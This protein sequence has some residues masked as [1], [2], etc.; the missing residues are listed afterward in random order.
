MNDT[1]RDERVA[2]ATLD[3]ADAAFDYRIREVE[4]RLDRRVAALESQ[5]D[6]LRW[7]NRLMGAGLA[8]SLVAIVA[9]LATVSGGQRT[10]A[11]RSLHAEE[12]VLRDGYGVMRGRL[13]TDSDG[14]ALLS[15]SDRDGR[16]RIRLTVLADGS[17]GVTISDADARPRAVLGYLPD[18]TTSLVLADAQGVS[19]AVVG[20]EPDGATHALFSDS[21]GVIRTLVG[22]SADGV[23]A[24]SVIDNVPR[25]P[26]PDD[27]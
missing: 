20:L 10:V 1:R 26:V 9:V 18:G 24:F 12:V 7:M 25:G 22:V 23:P 14:R 13:G 11:T 16:A 19:R 5:R 15:L 8:G 4:A 6:R 3:G 21:G 2:R 27:Q 17:P